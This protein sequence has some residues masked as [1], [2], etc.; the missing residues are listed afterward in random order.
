MFTL[1]DLFVCKNKLINVVFISVR[2]SE[3][4]YVNSSLRGLIKLFVFSYELLYTFYAALIN[5]RANNSLSSLRIRHL[6]NTDTAFT[7]LFR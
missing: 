4:D 6:G 3:V 1:L 7:L 5:L 2:A